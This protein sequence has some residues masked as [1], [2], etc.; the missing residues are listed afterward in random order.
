MLAFVTSQQHEN[1]SGHGATRVKKI[2]A[3]T[4]FC[5]ISYYE[6]LIK[7]S[8]TEYFRLSS[9]SLKSSVMQL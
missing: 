7:L 4:E 8:T 3:S 5:C 9:I 6:F 2:A 1:T